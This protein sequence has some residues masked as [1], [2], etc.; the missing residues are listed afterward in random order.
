MDFPYEI[1]FSTTAG[2]DLKDIKKYLKK[3]ASETIANKVIGG[4]FD[5]IE[6]LK[7]QPERYPQEPLLASFGNYRVIRKGVYKVYYEF[8]GYD[9]YILRIIHNRR[10]VKRIFKKWKM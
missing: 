7:E 10:D 6:T 8:T 4:L 3:H 1:A 5:A 2:R 9:I